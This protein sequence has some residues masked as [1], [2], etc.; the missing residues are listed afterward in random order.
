MKKSKLSDEELKQLETELNKEI[1]LLFEK[2]WRWLTKNEK[3]NLSK[4][5][6]PK[7]MAAVIN[8]TRHAAN[9][10][11]KRGYHHGCIY[12]MNKILEELKK[13]NE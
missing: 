7:T 6:H 12:G 4:F 5:E 1:E 9:V 11:F 10:L 8:L 3:K 2:E 13:G